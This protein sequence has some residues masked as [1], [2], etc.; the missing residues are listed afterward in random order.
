MGIQ[1]R[2]QPHSV[3]PIL[4]IYTVHVRGSSVPPQTVRVGDRT[5]LRR[6]AKNSRSFE[7]N[8]IMRRVYV[9]QSMTPFFA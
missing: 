9:G 8:S 7:H 4:G 6:L 2:N 3:E 5:A 1:Q